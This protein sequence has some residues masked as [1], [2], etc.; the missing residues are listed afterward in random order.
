MKTF[1]ITFLAFLSVA[2]V[3]CKPPEKIVTGTVFLTTPNGDATRQAGT[4][5]LLLRPSFQNSLDSLQTSFQKDV[6][7]LSSNYSN[8]LKELRQ[9]YKRDREALDNVHLD[10]INVEWNKA[11]KTHSIRGISDIDRRL[12]E[13]RYELRNMPGME[14]LHVVLREPASPVPTK[15]VILKGLDWVSAFREQNQP[16]Y[17]E[18]EKSL[19]NIHDQLTNMLH[20]ARLPE[21]A[22]SSRAR[23]DYA[24]NS[25]DISYKGK[26]HS[27]NTDFEQSSSMI[28]HAYASTFV[29]L[30]KG[31]ILN[32]TVTSVDGE[33]RFSGFPPEC[34]IFSQA[35]MLAW[36]ETVTQ[37]PK[38]DLGPFNGKPHPALAFSE[39]QILNLRDAGLVAE[40][41]A[42][43]FN[44]DIVDEFFRK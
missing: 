9:N 38:L 12:K 11:K 10:R 22:N 15:S 4:T 40:S 27:L 23:Y 21:F 7:K 6:A 17:A 1:N 29:E 13:L 16:L 25:L 43:G 3:C 44:A 31:N 41:F 36:V 20:V 19:Q 28:S 26:I 24:I 34:Y 32:R 35:G 37:D 30:V 8:E 14:N 18:A 33:Y 39:G 5:V 42:Q 2:F